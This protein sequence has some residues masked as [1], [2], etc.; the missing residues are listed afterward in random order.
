LPSVL[1]KAEEVMIVAATEKATNNFL[2]I[3]FEFIKLLKIKL[4]KTCQKKI[5]C[6]YKYFNGF[7]KSSFFKPTNL[8]P[9]IDQIPPIKIN[10]QPNQ[11][12]DIKG[13]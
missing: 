1:A 12:K 2:F 7:L 3:I 6:S 11:I 13:L 9:N 5:D 8:F 4:I 10:K